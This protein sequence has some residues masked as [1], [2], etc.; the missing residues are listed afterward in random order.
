MF[1]L[2]KG[3]INIKIHDNS[4]STFCADLVETHMTEKTFIKGKDRDL[5][6]VYLYHAKQAKSAKHQC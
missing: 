1:L 6:S 3:E 4:H 5:E 2:A